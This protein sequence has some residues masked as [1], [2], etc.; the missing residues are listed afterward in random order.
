MESSGPVNPALG[1]ALRRVT[2]SAALAAFDWIGRGDG[3]DGGRAALDAMRAA[4]AEVDIDAAVVI[5]SATKGEAPQPERGE[6]LGHSTAAF[7][8]DIA[9]DPVEGTSYLARG[10][11]NALAVL[12]VAP[13]GTMMDPGPA[14][15]MEKFVAP[16]PARGKIDP[17][18]RTG[19]KLKVLADAL[20]K[21]V[22]DLTIYVLEKPR[23]R[24]L[25]EDILASGARVALYPAGDV[26]GALLAAIPGSGID[27][28]MGT[29]GTPEGVMSACAIRAL[30]GEFVARFD[31]QLHTETKAVREAG[32]STSRWYERDEII[33]SD[34]VFFCATGITTGLMLEGV[35]RTKSHY[36]VQT[37]MIT[38]A[39][40]ERQILTS[41]L[42][43]ERMK[44]AETREVA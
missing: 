43:L 26:A 41:H 16:A 29:G 1:Y 25:I 7:K 18:W 28:L 3:M 8:A 2:E 35:E 10:Q 34:N 30:G 19:R 21:D 14:F 36:K 15:Y 6:R 12:A 31:P 20:R 17:R 4:L 9:V 37:M 44:S 32:L 22:T 23:H 11:T 33:G 42:P 39:T 27:A 40:G 38:G 5:G 13:R 24:E